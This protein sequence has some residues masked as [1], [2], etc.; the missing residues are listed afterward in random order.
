[1]DFFLEGVEDT[2]SNAV[3]TAQSL[4]HLF[5]EDSVRV[6]A[7]GRSAS[8]VL[9]VFNALCARPITTINDIGQ[10]AG[11]SFP[12]ATKGIERLADLGIV[13]ERTGGRRNRVFA[14]DRYLQLLNK[15][16]E[17]L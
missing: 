1:L 14:Y 10:R 4:A 11:L 2:A 12:A 6:Q 8:T 13:I 15:G 17:P 3:Q 7:V 9:R 16:T 5:K